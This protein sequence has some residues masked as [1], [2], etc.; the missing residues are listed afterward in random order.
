LDER[1]RSAV[2][3]LLFFGERKEERFLPK[4][5]SIRRSIFRPVIFAPRFGESFLLFLSQ[6]LPSSFR[7]PKFQFFISVV[8][9][10]LSVQK[11]ISVKINEEI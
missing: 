8:R 11:F 4:P 2:R 3:Q 1:Q 5:L 6:N 7:L 9:E 10:M